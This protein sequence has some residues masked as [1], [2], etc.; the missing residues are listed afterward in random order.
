[1]NILYSYETTNTREILHYHGHK[2]QNLFTLKQNS[3]SNIWH[4]HIFVSTLLL[5]K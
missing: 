4:H 1:M 5:L 3:T 2:E